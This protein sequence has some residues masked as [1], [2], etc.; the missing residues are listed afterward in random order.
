MISDI[1]SIANKISRSMPVELGRF[2]CTC[3]FY[4]LV[5]FSSVGNGSWVP[6]TSVKSQPATEAQFEPPEKNIWLFNIT[7]DPYEHKDVSHLRTDVVMQMLDLL[8]QYNKTAVPCRYPKMDDK[9]N[10][11]YLG[12][13]WGPWL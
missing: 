4:V 6:P 5:L 2:H 8:A 13:Y 12:G 7:A 1:L 11:K 10:P 9:A 3:F